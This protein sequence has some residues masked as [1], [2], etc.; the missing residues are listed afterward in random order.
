MEVCVRQPAAVEDGGLSS[1]PRFGPGLA[2]EPGSVETT[3]SY[4][5]QLVKSPSADTEAIGV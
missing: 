3:A 4:G 5:G 1:D 2:E